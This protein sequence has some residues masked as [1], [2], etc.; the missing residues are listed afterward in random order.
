MPH[1]V[2]RDAN[3]T[4]R[5]LKQVQDR[6]RIEWN[7]KQGSVK[8][9]SRSKSVNRVPRVLLRGPLKLPWNSQ[10]SISALATRA[11]IRATMAE[12]RGVLRTS[13]PV[14]RGD[15]LFFPSPSYPTIFAIDCAPYE[16]GGCGEAAVP[17]EA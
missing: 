11:S 14:Q 10:P 2:L 1:D 12:W 6:G 16:A 8:P 9:S 13:A 7:T 4:L 15:Q 17:S 5:D 3:R